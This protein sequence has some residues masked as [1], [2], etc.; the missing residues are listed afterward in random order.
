LLNHLRYNARSDRLTR[1]D[2]FAA[3]LLVLAVAIHMTS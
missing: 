1:R 2:A 3:A